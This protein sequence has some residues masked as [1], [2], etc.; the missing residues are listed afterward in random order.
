M[1]LSVSKTQF[2]EGR[3]LFK[4]EANSLQ[5]NGMNCNGNLSFDK[6]VMNFTKGIL[7]EQN[8]K[9]GTYT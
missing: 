2:T 9:L 3:G 1:C 7:I 4:I 5:N 6:F 8:S